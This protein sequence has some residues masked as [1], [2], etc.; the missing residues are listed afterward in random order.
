M[1]AVGLNALNYA[2]GIDCFFILLFFIIFFIFP[3]FRWG[4]GQPKVILFVV[5]D[6]SFKGLSDVILDD[7]DVV[8]LKLM[9]RDDSFDIVAE[10][11]DHSVVVD[12]ANETTIF[13]VFLNLIF[14]IEKVLC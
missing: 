10:L 14:A 13:G 2:S 11:N 7:L 12:V 6:I 4:D 3:Q 1:N 9:L 8:D 5:A